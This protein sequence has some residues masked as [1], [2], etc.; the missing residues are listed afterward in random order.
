MGIRYMQAQVG[1]GVGDFT[2]SSFHRATSLPP[3]EPTPSSVTTDASYDGSLCLNVYREGILMTRTCIAAA[4][5]RF[6]SLAR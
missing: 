6:S 1:T 3:I 2:T 5:P 4:D